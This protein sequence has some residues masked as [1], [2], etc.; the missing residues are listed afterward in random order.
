VGLFGRDRIK[1]GVA[2]TARVVSISPT[3]KGA[4]Q[5]GKRDIECSLRIEVSVS[6]QPSY[7]VEHT[8]E[9][10][11]AKMPLI[12]DRLPVLVSASDPDRLRIDWDTAPDLA[13]RSLQASA[14]VARGN[15]AGAATVLGFT[16][17]EDNPPEDRSAE[18][19]S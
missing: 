6:G 19:S 5:T 3:A 9:V 7:A 18:A 2:G 8:D 17:R 15:V 13:T 12:G 4:K 14:E 16:L 1:D 11:H 10:P